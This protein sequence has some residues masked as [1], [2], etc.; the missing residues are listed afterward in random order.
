[1][2]PRQNDW[3][4]LA[5]PMGTAPA[6]P[7]L[8]HDPPAANFVGRR[9]AGLR[10]LAGAEI[11][12][13]VPTGK[14]TIGGD[15]VTAD[16]EDWRRTGLR[17]LAKAE[18]RSYT[19]TMKDNIAHWLIERGLAASSVRGMMGTGGAGEGQGSVAVRHGA[20]RSTRDRGA[21]RRI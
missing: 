4:F 17:P 16:S 21:A 13:P 18:I 8:R 15:P 3:A 7:P 2:T 19:P 10:P 9:G 20:D 14:D 12:S 5:P 6:G 1:M 11:S